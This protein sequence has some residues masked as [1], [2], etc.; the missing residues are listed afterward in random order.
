M[1]GIVGAYRARGVSEEAVVRMRDAIAHR[2]PDDAGVTISGG[3]RVGLGH[4]RLSIIDLSPAGH[5]PMTN[6]DGTLWL[7]FNGEIYNYAALREQLIGLGHQFRSHSDAETIIHAYEEWGIECVRDF[8]GMFA[9]AIWDERRQRLTLARDHTGIKPLFYYFDGRT[10]AFASEIKALWALDGLDRSIDRSAVFDYLTYM[11]VP[12]PKTAYARVRKLEAAHWLVLESNAIA[13]GCYWDVELTPRGIDE[14]AAVA[15][16]QERLREAVELNMVADV[17]VGVFL[18]GGIDSSAVVSYMS[19]LA[20]GPVRSYAI[21][22]DVPEHNE[23]TWARI[24]ADRYGTDHRERIVGRESVQQLLPELVRMYDEPY[25]DGSAMP[26]L[27]VSALA[28]ADVKVVLSGDGGDEVFAGY[29]WYDRW[30]RQQRFARAVPLPLRRFALAPLGALWPDRAPGVEAR[31]FLEGVGADPLVQY[32]RQ[33]ELFTPSEKRDLL[34]PDW[35]A[36]MG[37]YDDYWHLRRF[38]RPEVDPI[39][40]VQYVDLKTYLPDDILTKVDRATMSVALEARPPLLDHRLIEAVFSVPVAVRVR[41][42]EKK[43]LLKR[44]L[45]DRLPAAILD[46]GKKGFSSPLMQ[47]MA[48]ERGWAEG[49]LAA[50]PRLVRPGATGRLKRRNFG[51]KIWSLLV[52]EQWARGEAGL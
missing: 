27:R 52:L 39:T 3:G 24:V 11:Y 9:F 31:H 29:R 17:P 19:E 48:E 20:R 36:D 50:A 8:R 35:A 5:Q 22:F 47:W 4:R 42:A 30:L 32:G 21:G 1:C 13:T 49:F 25:C 43:Y 15:L 41:H 2:G 51:P 37:D 33:M 14:P 18:S 10:F 40:R 34:G 28:R 45:A 46:R 12:A 7:V 16:V 26:T 44:A 6:E 23:V 38:W